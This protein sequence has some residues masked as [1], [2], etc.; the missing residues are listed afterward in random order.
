MNLSFK[1]QF[2][3][4]IL[5]GTKIHTIREDK[6][7]RWKEGNKIHF[8]TGARTKQRNVFFEGTCTCVDS[9]WISGISKIIIMNDTRRLNEDEIKEFAKNDGFDD[10]QDFWKWFSGKGEDYVLIHW[11]KRYTDDIYLPF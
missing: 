2:K 6:H 10:V 7:K 3:D 1:P 8:V 9:V 5:N 11:T 4:K